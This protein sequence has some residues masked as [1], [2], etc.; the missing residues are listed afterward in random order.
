MAR[1]SVEDIREEIKKLSKTIYKAKSVIY[2]GRG[3]CY[4]LAMEGALKLKEIKDV[5]YFKDVG[6]QIC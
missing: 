2:L 5:K 3:H 6:L 1:R 4:P